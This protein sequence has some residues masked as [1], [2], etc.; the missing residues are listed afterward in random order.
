M[1]ET[2]S[3]NQSTQA[4]ES[5]IH[6]LVE[7]LDISFRLLRWALVG[8]CAVYLLSGLFVVRQH[9]R[10]FVLVLGRVQGIGEERIKLPG[11][12]WTLP[13]PFAEI[14]RVDTERLRVVQTVEAPAP[15]APDAPPSISWDEY[16]L[17]ADANLVRGVW[18]LRYTVQ[19]P[20]AWS[21]DHVDG[22]QIL[23][24]ELSHAVIRTT[25]RFAVDAVLRM[26]VDSV[27]A[28]IEETLRRRVADIGLG[29]RIERVDLLSMMPPPPTSMA[30]DAVIQSEQDQSRLISEARAYAARVEKETAGEVA[31]RLA[32]AEAYRTRLVAEVSAEAAYFAAVQPQYALQPKVVAQTLH[33]ETL[34][35]ALKRVAGVYYVKPSADGKQELRLWLGPRPSMPPQS[36]R[37]ERR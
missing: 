31:R 24:N 10:A 37:E 6:A 5:G 4:P 32:E 13:R 7:A 30:F 2:T 1:S 9:E 3:E 27:R 14:R 15:T 29:A 33:Q 36:K 18:A 26:D 12:H 16:L 19:D 17:T 23:K 34:R 22:E 25:A 35:R 11:L 21:F 28:A 8:L 20:A